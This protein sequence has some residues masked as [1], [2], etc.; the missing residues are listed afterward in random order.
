[1]RDKNRS[2]QFDSLMKYS[3]SANPNAQMQ[4]NILEQLERGRGGSI[5]TIRNRWN[6][7]MGV[8]LC[9]AIKAARKAIP[10]LRDFHCIFC[11]SYMMGKDPKPPA[12]VNFD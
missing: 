8:P 6:V 4:E 2:K 1:M 5:L 11:R 10:S 3:D 7:F 9:D 12:Y